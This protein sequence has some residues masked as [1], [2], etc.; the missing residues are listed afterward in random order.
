M[1]STPT[2]PKK[3]KKPKEVTTQEEVVEDVVDL[4]D[5]ATLELTTTQQEAVMPTGRNMAKKLK[6]AHMAVVALARVA[7]RIVKMMFQ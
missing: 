1:D 7:A 4:D 5:I 6:R 3:K 2:V